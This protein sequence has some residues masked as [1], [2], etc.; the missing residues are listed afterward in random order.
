MSF[1]FSCPHI[2]PQNGKAERK[3]RRINYIIR[4]LLAHASIPPVFWH[5]A[6]QMTSYM[7]NIL[8][9]KKLTLQSPTKILYQKD[10][11]YS[12]LRVFG[13]LSYPLISSTT[14]NKLQPRSTPCV[15]LGYPSNHRDIRLVFFTD[16]IATLGFSHNIFDHSL[17]IYHHGIDTAY[18]LIF[19]DII[20][21][22]SSDV[23]RD[24]I[25]SK[26]S[27]EF[28]M[29]DLGPLS[30]FLGIFVTKHIG[31]LFYSKEICKGNY[32]TSK[33]VLLQAITHPSRH[34][35]KIQLLFWESIS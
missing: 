21:T 14:G 33:H 3:I 20:L 13:C 26:L 27:S 18:I 2:S 4:T 15:F 34:Q 31:D 23:L 6:L 7:H 1:R 11:S 22:T 16:Y 10:P 19:V 12:Y 8:P 25:M 30:Y 32:Q 28:A 17:F 29:K 24:S 5:H 35:G 9:N